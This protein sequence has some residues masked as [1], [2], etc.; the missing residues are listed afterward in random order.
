MGRPEVCALNNSDTDVRT[1][2]SRPV[3]LLAND[4]CVS[5]VSIGFGEYV[6]HDVEQ[7]DVRSGPPWDVSRSVEAERFNCAIGVLT[8]FE[9]STNDL[10]F[11][12]VRG[13]PFVGLKLGVGIPP[14]KMLR[15]R[16]TED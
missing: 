7:L 9:V 2:S 4:V 15:E 14:R 10:G 1:E 8:S 12:F 3:D 16:P 5:C 6:D 13:Y 11:G